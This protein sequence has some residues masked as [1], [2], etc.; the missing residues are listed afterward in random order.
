M[1]IGLWL[2]PTHR[3]AFWNWGFGLALANMVMTLL[4]AF[5]FI[6]FMTSDNA[7]TVIGLFVSPGVVVF[8]VFSIVYFILYC[9]LPITRKR[10]F[11]SP[12]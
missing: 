10:T 5:A 12:K 4:T 8:A 11:C 3:R 7:G 9:T 2:N 1:S 6:A